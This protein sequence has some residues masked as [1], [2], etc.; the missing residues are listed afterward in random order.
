MGAGATAK[1][2]TALGVSAVIDGAR[3][4]AIVAL[5]IAGAGIPEASE[6]PLCITLMDVPEPDTAPAGKPIFESL[7][8]M[9]SS[10]STD[11]E[12]DNYLRFRHD[13]KFMF[14]VQK[15]LHSS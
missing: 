5:E 14:L 11:S 6:L 13:G 10:F 1:G 9:Q 8:S 7:L 3:T 15:I 12:D 4:V 2:A